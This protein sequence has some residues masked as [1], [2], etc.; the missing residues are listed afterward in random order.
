MLICFP[1]MRETKATCQPNAAGPSMRPW[2][3]EE[4]VN[5]IIG[6]FGSMVCAD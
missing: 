3:R 4:L 6:P 2:I 1:K 5:G